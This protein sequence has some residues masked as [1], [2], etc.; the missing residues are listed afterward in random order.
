VE[1]VSERENLE[2]G[3]DSVASVARS[4][5]ISPFGKKVSIGNNQ[6]KV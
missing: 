4:G 1:G 3:G 6:N 5:E 2:L